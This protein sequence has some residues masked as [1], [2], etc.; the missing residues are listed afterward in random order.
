[1][2]LTEVSVELQYSKIYYLTDASDKLLQ[3]STDEYRSGKRDMHEITEDFY[4]TEKLGH[5]LTRLNK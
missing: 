3:R 1:M 4:D 5:R 2:T